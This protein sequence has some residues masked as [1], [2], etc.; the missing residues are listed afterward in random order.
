MLI[1]T[2]LINC[3][4]LTRYQVSE[5]INQFYDYLKIEFDNNCKIIMIP[6]NNQ[7]TDVKIH[8]T[9]NYFSIELLQKYLIK[10]STF[11]KSQYIKNDIK[12]IIRF[13]KIKKLV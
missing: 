3:D 2:A 1:I 13:L 5:K 9:E 6:V 7:P 4:N 10:I 11:D 8:N 12:K